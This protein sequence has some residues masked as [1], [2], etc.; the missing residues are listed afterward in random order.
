[1][2]T[3]LVPQ[4]WVYIGPMD[5]KQG[6]AARFRDVEGDRV[7]LFKMASVKKFAPYL[8][9]GMIFSVN[10]ND[11]QAD[12]ATLKHTGLWPDEEDRAQWQTAARAFAL[13]KA[14]EKK[15]EKD[16]QDNA[17]LTILEPLRREYQS[18]N[19]QTKLVLEVLVLKALRTPVK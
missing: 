18:T 15:A 6:L 8:T 19:Y 16:A 10:A 17:L 3:D 12:L 2:S 4:A 11:T 7:R 1:M 9:P 13:E 5:G 14:A